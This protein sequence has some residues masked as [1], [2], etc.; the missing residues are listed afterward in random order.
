MEDKH[1]YT[2]AAS[3]KIKRRILEYVKESKSW[4][5]EFTKSYKTD[6]TKK[7]D[8]VKTN[9]PTATPTPSIHAKP[10]LKTQNIQIN[11]YTVSKKE[12]KKIKK[13]NVAAKTG[14]G[15]HREIV[16]S[17][18]SYSLFGIIIGIIILSILFSFK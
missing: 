12:E 11:S 3:E 10:K 9:I 6:K 16:F 1:I 18:V 13:E 5:D 14:F 17:V 15:I 7:P 8:L 4:V 2:T